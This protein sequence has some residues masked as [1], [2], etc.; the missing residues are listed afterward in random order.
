VEDDALVREALGQSLELAGFAPHLTSSF[1]VAKDHILAD[2][3]GVILSD[4]R[5][6]GRDG[7]HLLDYAQS[8]DP[9]LPVILLTGEG[10]IP[11][12]VAAIRKGAFDFLEKPCANDLLVGTVRRALKSRA[13][14]IENRHLKRSLKAGDAAARMIFGTSDKAEAL[15][16]QVRT[17]ARVDD[18]V[19][20][21]GAPGSGVAKVAEVVHLLSS[22]AGG[23]FV[24][25]A[26]VS[27]APEALARSLVSAAGGSLYIDEIAALPPETQF[28]LLRTVEQAGDA[29][30]LAGSTKAPVAGHGPGEIHPDLYYRLDGLRIRI[31]PLKER[32]EDIPVI[33]RQYVRQAAEQS[34]APEPPV[35]AEVIADLMAQDWPGNSRALM[36]AAMR[37][38]LGIDASRRGDDL[39]LAEKLAQ[40]ERTLIVEALQRHQ[41]N[42]SATAMQLKLPRKTFYDKLSKHGIRPE[43]YR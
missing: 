23:P 35:T 17:V 36:N 27:L 43:D 39:G 41:G 22:N 28:E 30:I 7:M 6:P 42:A 15:R 38:V 8:V 9:V 26:A 11:M 10:D 3:E 24:R 25:V 4:M 1:I 29:R 2:F 16:A 33:F 32:P 12:A 34:N 37:F 31:P 13:L 14:V 40:L 20:V 18:A 19:L 5:M 21:E